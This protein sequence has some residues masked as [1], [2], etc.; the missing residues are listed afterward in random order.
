MVQN[1]TAPGGGP[2]AAAGSDFANG[3]SSLHNSTS[4]SACKAALGLTIA[5]CPKG[6]F[7]TKRFFLD[8]DDSERVLEYDFVKRWQFH[9]RE[10]ADLGHLARLLTALMTNPRACI[11][12]GA[13]TIN[14][15]AVWQ[16]RQWASDKPTLRAV[17]RQW[18]A[19]DIDGVS[20]PAPLGKAANLAEAAEHVRDRLLPPEFRCVRCVVT[21]TASTGRKGDAVLRCRLWFLLDRAISDAE[22][23]RWAQAFRACT[24]FPLDPAVLQTGQPNYVARPLFGSPLVEPVPEHCR[25]VVVNG[26]C[27]QVAL[28]L[29]A[30]AQQQREINR[31][32][33]GK[34]KLAGG[35]WRA[36]AAATI[37]GAQSFYAPILQ[38]IG[39]GVDQGATD[40]EIVAVVSK[41]V[42][43]R[44]DPGRRR[45]YNER[46]L[47]KQVR[48]IKQL[49][50]KNYGV[51][52]PAWSTWTKTPPSPEQ[53]AIIEKFAHEYLTPKIIAAAEI[54]ELNAFAR[55]YLKPRLGEANNERRGCL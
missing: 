47:A 34:V 21:A 31:K 19:L 14:D 35:G 13:P 37:G 36:A 32:I 53:I 7:A 22:L 51:G 52:G 33:A 49:D 27:D 42:N 17:A 1:A 4:V 29:N 6:Q 23:F 26:C 2:G 10:F 39:R 50:D 55:D 5:V 46:W 40:Q 9:P 3:E 8:C 28:N 45:Q 54:D 15:P 30:Y 25:V 11:L 20:V 44:A 48:G 16:L 43:E 12:R 38:T 24:D 41:I 18:V